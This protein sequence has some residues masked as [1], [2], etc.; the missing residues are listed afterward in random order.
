MYG[1]VCYTNDPILH[2]SQ[3]CVEMSLN[4][5]RTSAYA[6]WLLTECLDEGVAHALVRATSRLI[7]TH[8]RPSFLPRL[9]DIRARPGHT[10]LAL[11]FPLF[12]AF[13]I[14]GA[15]FGE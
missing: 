14:P 6:T 12:S 7:S 5:A 9:V 15:L 2:I 4:A 8:G 3:P 10:C 13:A 1:V 11:F